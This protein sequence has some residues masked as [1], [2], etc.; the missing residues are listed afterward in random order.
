MRNIC[1]TRSQRTTRRGVSCG[2]P[3]GGRGNGRD[4]ISQLARDELDTLLA[5][6]PRGVLRTGWTV[7][8]FQLAEGPPCP[9]RGRTRQLLAVFPGL[10][11][12]AG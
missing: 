7:G 9:T 5:G 12:H 10:F 3:I 11:R 4:A 1:R 8:Q 6:I 2:R